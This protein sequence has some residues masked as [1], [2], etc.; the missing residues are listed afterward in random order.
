MNDTE[1]INMQPAEETTVRTAINTDEGKK[2][3]SKTAAEPVNRPADPY[4]WGIFLI[5]A[6]ISLVITYDASSRE[7]SGANI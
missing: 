1:N 7:V 6:M 2:K 5:L 3:T 4:I